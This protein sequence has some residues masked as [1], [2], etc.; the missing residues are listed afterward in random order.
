MGAAL[1]FAEVLFPKRAIFPRD[2]AGPKRVQRLAASQGRAA[3]DMVGFAQHVAQRIDSRPIA[4]I[5][6]NIGSPAKP[7]AGDRGRMP[8]QDQLCRSAAVHRRIPSFVT[9]PFLL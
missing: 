6:R 2:L 9:G 3:P 5:G 1:P 8:Y 7:P 4:Q